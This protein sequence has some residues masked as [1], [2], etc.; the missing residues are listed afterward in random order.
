MKSFVRQSSLFLLLGFFVGLIGCGQDEIQLP[1]QVLQGKID[2]KDWEMKFANAYIF[3]SDLK[4]QIRFLSTVESGEDPCAI[5]STANAHVSMVF[6]PQIGSFSIPLPIFEESARFN[7][8]LGNSVVATS[9]F[10]EIFDISNSRIFGYLQAHLDD[11]NSVEG[12]FEAVF[13]N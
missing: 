3:S 5:P 4:Y 10:L 2:G 6:R 13:C 12:S 1:D 11:D 7:V 8:N 9:G